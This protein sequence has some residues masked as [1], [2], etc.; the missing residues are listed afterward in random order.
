MTETKFTAG[1]WTVPH[2]DTRE[3]R[4][5]GRLNDGAFIVMPDLSKRGGILGEQDE[6]AIC[7]VNFRGLA[8]RGEAWRTED[9]EG[10]AN[11]CLISAAPEL[12]AAVSALL[13]ASH[14]S[15][16]DQ[17]YGDARRAAQALAT[18]ALAKAAP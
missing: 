2:H 11:A 17:G 3:G 18:A 9:V 15:P 5:P 7:A 13:K 10:L 1:P 12:L 4:V 8:K 6:R 14:Y 16:S